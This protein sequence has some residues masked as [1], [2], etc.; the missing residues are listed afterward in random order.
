MKRKSALGFTLV[1]V[2]VAM[3]IMA[4][5]AGMAWQGVDGIVRSRDASQGRL[6]QTL[7]LN[8]LLAQ[9]E[10]DL[11]AV[12]QT[13][14]VP[15]L[16]FDG[17]SLRLTRRAERGLQVVV[18]SRRPGTDGAPSSASWMR[19][20]GPAVT[21]STELQDYWLRTQQ[22]QGNEAGQLKGLTGLSQWQVYCFR[23]NAWS[24]CQSSGDVKQETASPPAA[25]GSGVP[26]PPREALP[27]GVRLV[28][29][30]AEGSGF[31]GS[32][33]RDVALGPQWP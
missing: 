11:A 10:Q 24:N 23:G 16:T 18:W 27:T 28:L 30:F 15:A 32:L 20:A 13:T 12:Q 7:R 26:R 17:A 6:E 22:F 25:A 3:V 33:T 21:S 8:T 4:I 9:W 29:E 14:A 1:E 2:L 5:L 31:N 19:W